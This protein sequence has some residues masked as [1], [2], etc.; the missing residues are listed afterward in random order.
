V[1]SP[2]AVHERQISGAPRT[3]R[4][5]SVE[6]RRVTLAFAVPPAFPHRRL[7]LGKS[8][9]AV[10]QDVDDELDPLQARDR[11]VV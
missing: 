11:G 2:L 9:K 4:H 7:L 10:A 1:N 6:R 8:G 3:D 5:N